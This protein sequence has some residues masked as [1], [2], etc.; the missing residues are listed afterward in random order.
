MMG[1]GTRQE[2]FRVSNEQ[3]GDSAH[4]SLFG[5][6]DVATTP[7]LEE[8]IHAAERN[9]STAIIVDLEQVTFMDVSGLRAFLG[10]AQRA[11]R[12]GRTFAIVKAPRVVQRVLQI[13]GTTHLVAPIP[14]G[15]C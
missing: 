9:G 6:I 4:L 12:S 2:P 14:P 10:A 1:V 13:T 7:V 11:G 15:G 8:W 5:E 3:R